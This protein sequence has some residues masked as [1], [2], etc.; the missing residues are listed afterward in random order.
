MTTLRQ[1]LFDIGR[2]AA[3][4]L[5]RFVSIHDSIRSRH[6]LLFIHVDFAQHA[7]DARMIRDCF[8]ALM[9]RVEAAIPSLE[10]ASKDAGPK[11]GSVQ[12][13]MILSRDA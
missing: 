3:D 2:L 5:G 12:C 8:D 9:T 10:P 6:V 7:R 4:M 13:F 1:E 11:T